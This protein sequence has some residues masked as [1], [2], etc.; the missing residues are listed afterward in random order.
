MCVFVFRGFRFS[1]FF[2]NDLVR[3]L[4]A[5]FAVILSLLIWTG[6]SYAFPSIQLEKLKVPQ[7]FEPTFQCCTSTC[8][9]GWPQDCE[10]QAE[11]WG[12]R[13]WIVNLGE[14]NGVTW[15]PFMAA[16][17]AILAFLLVYLDNGIT[18]HLVNHPSNKLCHGEAYNY[19][20][21]LSGF[22]NIV[23]AILGLPPLVATTVPCIVHVNSLSVKDRDGNILEVQETRLTHF[24]SHM[25]IA[26]SVLA[27]DALR[28]LP[29]PVLYGV[30]LFMGLSSLGGIQMWHRFLLFFQQPE[31]YPETVY[32]KYMSKGRIHLYT[33]MQM[34][35]FGL[36][37]FVQNFKPIAIAFPF[38]TMLCIPGRL[39]LFSRVFEGWE[40][41]LL[42]GDDIDIERWIVLKEDNDKAVAHIPVSQ[43][44]AGD[45]KAL[46][47]DD[48]EVD[49]S[50]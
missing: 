26:L 14:L 23:N 28:L 15:V 35:F 22:F 30:F 16:G 34:C 38:M 10:D 31:K 18:W 45:K 36:V 3:N 48:D 29:L 46:D 42:D 40:L 1:S 37:F 11:P 33:V 47:D 25:L 2:C 19:D 43:R 5:D 9:S 49:M 39:F 27:L 4:I 20:I 41:L 24:F 6:V 7:K 21:I 8:D 32:T 44:F 13:P 12:T 17:P 50:V